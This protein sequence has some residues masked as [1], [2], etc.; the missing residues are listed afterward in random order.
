MHYI[1]EL[2]SPFISIKLGRRRTSIELE[3][4]YKNGMEKTR[5][6]L[7]LSFAVAVKTN[8]YS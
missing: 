6:G 7:E 3:D 2:L 8:V 4:K 1:E 5:T